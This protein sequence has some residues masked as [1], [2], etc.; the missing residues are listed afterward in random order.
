MT[1]VKQYGGNI[2][3]YKKTLDWTFSF[4]PYLLTNLPEYRYSS[5]HTSNQ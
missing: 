1:K 5:L 2:Q 4:K 3:I